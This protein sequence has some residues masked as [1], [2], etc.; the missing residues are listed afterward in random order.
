MYSAPRRAV[1]RGS[2]QVGAQSITAAKLAVLTARRLGYVAA[3]KK[4]AIMDKT[5]ICFSQSGT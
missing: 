5:M 3:A 2:G 1:Q 4:R